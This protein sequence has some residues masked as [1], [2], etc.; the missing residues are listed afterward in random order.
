MYA[1]S[2][3][4]PFMN[5]PLSKEIMTRNRLGNKFI[6]DRSEDKKEVFKTTQLF[7]FTSNSNYFGNLNEKMPVIKKH[8]GK[9]LNPFY[10][11]K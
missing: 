7:C 5:E 3:H 6:K 10:W 9:P 4:M 11:I 1:R 2:N 8:F